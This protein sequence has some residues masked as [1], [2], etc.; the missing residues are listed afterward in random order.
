MPGL[1]FYY[2]TKS[3]IEDDGNITE[4]IVR[5][6]KIDTFEIDYVGKET[7]SRKR[8]ENIQKALDLYLEPGLHIIFNKFDK[9]ERQ[10]S[11]KLKQF[12][13]RL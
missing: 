7:L 8:T 10:K 4:L 11:G 13:S 5:Q 6:T 12:V 1:T 9:I 3:V 2:V